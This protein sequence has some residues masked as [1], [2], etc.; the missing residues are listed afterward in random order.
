MKAFLGD[1]MKNIIVIGGGPAGM[2]AA[3]FAGKN[4]ENNVILLEK[5]NKIGRKLFITGKGRCNVTNAC[6]VDE[7]IQNTGAKVMTLM[8]Q[9]HLPFASHLSIENFQTAVTQRVRTPC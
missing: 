6:E 7:L 4:K 9:H 3:G 2:I 5:N 1:L 8:T